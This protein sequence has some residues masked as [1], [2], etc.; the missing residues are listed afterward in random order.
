[1]YSTCM[2]IMYVLMDI[3]H[4]SHD[5]HIT[6]SYSYNASLAIYSISRTKIWCNKPM[7]ACAHVW[8]TMYI[9]VSTMNRIGISWILVIIILLVQKQCDNQ[10]YR[11][12]VKYTIYIYNIYIISIYSNPKTHVHSLLLM[13]MYKLSEL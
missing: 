9:H 3:H 10:I 1:M 7:H 13:T 4:R 2:Y 8:L 11:V 6:I 5:I 12:Q